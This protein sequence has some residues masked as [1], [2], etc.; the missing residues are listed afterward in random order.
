M[1]TA[2]IY[3]EVIDT[4]DVVI[5][6][7]IYKNVEKVHFDGI[8]GKECI[9]KDIDSM[10]G[11]E[12]ASGQIKPSAESESI[13]IETGLKSVEYFFAMSNQFPGSNNTCAWYDTGTIFGTAYTTKG[14]YTSITY[15]SKTLSVSKN[16]GIV[17]LGTYDESH[18]IQPY[19]IKWIA[20]G[21]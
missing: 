8:G 16:G 15:F 20:I 7:V 13:E 14:S 19:T 4:K 17:T 11:L 18:M 2:Y 1:E 9:F 10:V 21:R 12:V 6:N 5:G 3:P